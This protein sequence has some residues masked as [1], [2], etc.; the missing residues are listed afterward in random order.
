MR[1]PSHDR[2]EIRR[3][4]QVRADEH[5]TFQQLADRTGIPAHVFVYRSGQDRPKSPPEASASSRFVE[6][7]DR[8]ITGSRNSDSGVTIHLAG[9]HRIA[10]ARNF[11]AET[12]GKLLSALP[13]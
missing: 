12:L 6:L 1:T 3:L 10:L 13:C 4:L 5:L 9:G 2:E 7:D 11:D 8:S